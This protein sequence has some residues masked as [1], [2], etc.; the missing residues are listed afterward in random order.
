MLEVPWQTQYQ[1]EAAG[2][3]DIARLCHEAVIREY[4]A[5]L[6]LDS[7]QTACPGMT[8]EEF[9]ASLHGYA[10]SRAEATNIRAKVPAG[11]GD[12]YYWESHFA[13]ASE[14]YRRALQESPWMLWVYAKYALLWIGSVGVNPRGGLGAI[15]RALPG[16]LAK[17]SRSS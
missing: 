4:I 12:H 7:A 2:S 1:A 8:W 17:M 11:L 15:R 14:Y 3:E 16:P 10:R 9:E 5:Q 13:Q 6:S